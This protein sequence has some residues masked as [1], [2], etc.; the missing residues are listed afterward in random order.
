MQLS[1]N[2]WLFES[3]CAHLYISIRSIKTRIV[4]QMRKASFYAGDPAREGGKMPKRRWAKRAGA[5]LNGPWFGNRFVCR[6]IFSRALIITLNLQQSC[7]LRGRKAERYA[8][9]RPG[10]LQS[11]WRAHLHHLLSFPS[12][13]PRKVKRLAAAAKRP[14]NRLSFLGRRRCTRPSG[15]NT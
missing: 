13:P 8:S 2:C 10:A 1:R 15:T 9:P 6:I 4:S 3:R 12:R 7:S 14:L 5:A 11:H